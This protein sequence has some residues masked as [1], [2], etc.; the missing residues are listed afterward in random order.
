MAPPV[1]KPLAGGK[2]ILPNKEKGLFAKLIQEYE[3]KKYKIGL[4]TADQILKKFP[5][6]GET[7]CM[8]GLILASLNRQNEGLELAKQGLRFDLTSFIS[9][10]ALGILNRIV[11]NY[12]ESIK[13]YS[14]ALRI[15]GGT[16]INLVRESA[17][18][19]MQL[20]DWP[21]VV[22]NRLTLVRM[23]PHLR[24]NW[25]GLAVSLHLGGDT[26]EALR[27]LEHFESI[28]RDVPKRSYEQSEVFLYHA[29]VLHE[30]GRHKDAIE[31]LSKKTS[32]QVLDVKASSLLQGKCQ[33]ALGE[34]E[35]AEKT[36][37]GLLQRNNE[38]RQYIAL[39]LK[40]K[41]VDVQSGKADSTAASAA[42][43]SL[44]EQFPSSRAIKRMTLTL[45]SGEEFHTQA[46]SYI[47]VALQKGVPSI[48]NDVRA[49]YVDDAKR[50]A[51]E[52]IVEG[53][54]EKWTK[55]PNEAPTSLLWTL[56][57]L[58]QHY[59]F[60]GQYDEALKHI[61]SAIAHSPTLPEL[62]MTRARIYKKA[63]AIDWANTAMED[64]RLLDGQDRSLNCKAAKYSLR[65]GDISGASKKAGLFTKPDVEDPVLD[66]VEMQASWYLIEEA[67]AWLAKGNYAMALKRCTQ[68]DKI[69]TEIWDD[70]L[71]FHSYC[72]RKFTLRAYVDMVRFED[73]LHSHHAYFSAATTAIRILLK[74]HDQP[75][76]LKLQNGTAAE[77][78]N[79]DQKKLSKKAKK[80]EEA[81]KK[82]AA[83]ANGKAEE[84]EV[85][86][87]PKDDD[88]DG[89][90]AF[91]AVDPLKDA[92]RYITLLQKHAPAQPETW[93]LSFEVALRGK[94]WLA[95]TKAIA[96]AHALEP[97]N[98]KVHYAILRLRKALPVLSEAPEPIRESISAVLKPIVPLEEG[99]LEAF[100]ATFVQR[101]AG[102]SAENAL[103][104][105]RSTLLLRGNN[106]D[107]KREAAAILLEMAKGAAAS[108]AKAGKS[109]VKLSTLQEAFEFLKECGSTDAAAFVEAS[110]QAYPLSDIFKTDAQK[111]KESIDRENERRS[112]AFAPPDAD[113][114][115]AAT[116]GQN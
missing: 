33:L 88:P 80:L 110:K 108:Y 56:Y 65:A 94:N 57:F 32:D 13:C 114:S 64:A 60:L 21:K 81:A 115:P 61:H 109:D 58:A 86:A 106:E 63:G 10:H 30:A 49:L 29:Q 96:R 100:N 15:E 99:T 77:N 55:D 75:S 72:T 8:K 48:F 25:A 52:N 71:D 16:N 7:L 28:H 116:N 79:D 82:N 51:I 70:Q 42:F 93:L 62:H 78:G 68:I 1:K 102:K 45:V 4:K 91:K 36:F 113:G 83:S 73:R 74:L 101:H 92:E 44:Q 9:W 14:Q 50:D 87:P 95:A 54:R 35:E 105:A 40:T 5:E 6:H 23:Q 76:L 67:R 43:K 39:W 34:V 31:F 97:E 46:S 18:L 98:G 111:E 2:T 53:A 38:D 85:N 47:L 103:A 27:V 107:G 37:N 89:R 66:L 112:W 17:Y 22:E 19:Y 12:N 104:S 41:G 69:Y 26:A 3:S 84:E 24:M 11:K 90:E 20:R 59:S